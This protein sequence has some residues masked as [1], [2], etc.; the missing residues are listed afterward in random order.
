VTVLV[1]NRVSRVACPL[2]WPLIGK[3]ETRESESFMKESSAR[4]VNHPK[5][6]IYCLLAS[7]LGLGACST[8]ANLG[9]MADG[10]S[11]AA[12]ADNQGGAAGTS[13]LPPM[14][15]AVGDSAGTGG[16]GASA[17]A[18][19]PGG[20]GGSGASAGAGSPGG[21]GG[22]GASAGAGS[23][24][25][26]GG[27]GA[28]AGTAGAGGAA[29]V[30]GVLLTAVLQE[31]S[32]FVSAEWH[33]GTSAKIFLRGCATADGWYRE[34]GEWKK[35]GVFAACTVEGLAVEVAPGATYRDAVGGVPPSRGDNVWR[36][37][38]PYGIGCT[39]GVK[40]SEANCAE[41]HEAISSNEVTTK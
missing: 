41:L 19:S 37:Q 2:D 29:G 14:A 12:A 4:L 15:G 39:S 31:A 7:L 32:G 36:L 22:S 16:S 21:M 27:S 26:M 40:F 28:S 23:P 6:P 3:T 9:S 35:Y 18:G 33:N 13:V 38:G 10:S 25:G 1:H 24:G 17:G 30:E 5:I 11:G 34:G 8:D 20:M